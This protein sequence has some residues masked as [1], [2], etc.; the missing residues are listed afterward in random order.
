MSL[1]D[2]SMPVHKSFQ[3]ADLLL[4]VPKSIF[5]ILLLMFILI[6]YLFGLIPA[7]ICTVVI[8]VP[9][10][11]LTKKDP[12]MLPIALSSLLEPDKLEG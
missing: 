4:G 3:Q 7:A 9:C 12:H 2:F 5:I 8:Y 10:R 11:I 1:T 6:A